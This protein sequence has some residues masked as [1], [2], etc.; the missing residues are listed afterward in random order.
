MGDGTY[1]GL[2]ILYSGAIKKAES[3]TFSSL[4]FRKGKMIHCG[5]VT[6]NGSFI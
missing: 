1:S 5:V 3:Y 4:T 6:C 2:F